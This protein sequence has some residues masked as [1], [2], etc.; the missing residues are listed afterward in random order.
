[1]SYTKNRSNT[2]I[3]LAMDTLYNY[4]NLINYAKNVQTSDYSILASRAWQRHIAVMNVQC[5]LETKPL[6]VRV[7]A[8]LVAY[9]RD[10]CEE[11]IV[12]RIIL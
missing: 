2:G 11:M 4:A 5:T 9:S 7:E 1:M 8:E 3:Q 12:P 6:S 10:Y